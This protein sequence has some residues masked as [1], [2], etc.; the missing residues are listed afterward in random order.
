MRMTNKIM[1]NNSL[2]NINQTK[3]AEDKYTTQMTSQSKID[4]PSDDPVVAIRA[5]RLRT[6][7]TEVTQYYEKNAPDA[8]QWLDVTAG[9]LTTVTDIIT[10]LYKQAE[11]GFNKELKSDDLQVILDQMKAYTKE[12]YATGNQDYAGRYIFTGYRTDMELTF[13]KPSTASYTITERFGLEDFDVFNYTND[14][15]LD[16]KTEPIDETKVSNTDL[17]RLRLS[18]KGLSTLTTSKL[19]I[20]VVDQDGNDARREDGTV[21]FDH[22][23]P[24]VSFEHAYS[25]ITQNQ[26]AGEG[27]QRTLAYGVGETGEIFFGDYIYNEIEKALQK[28][29]QLEVSYEKDSWQE[30][31]LHPEHFFSCVEHKDTGDIAYNSDFDV[32]KEINYDVGYNQKIQVNTNAN[33]VFIHDLYRDMDDLSKAVDELEKIESLKEELQKKLD[34]ESETSSDYSKIKDQLDATKKAYDY[35]RENVKNLFGG[36]MTKYQNYLDKTN[37][38]ITKNGTR[39]SRLELISSRLMDQQATYKELQEENEGVDMTETA[40]KLASAKLTYD[41]A[42]QATGKILQ[43]SL[44]NYI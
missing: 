37:L 40:V 10:N 41:A 19:V 3:I 6:N 13:S 36:Q 9:A 21:V 38:A 11:K 1:Q 30:G 24:P 8:N 27:V 7:V 17:H 14:D 28:G 25:E 16:S 42:L 4:R 43:N 23:T 35:V 12:F 5:L 39:S 18:Y 32:N 20:R 29:Y 15:I 34:A 33:E 2:Y 44:M 31:D 26:T 22:T